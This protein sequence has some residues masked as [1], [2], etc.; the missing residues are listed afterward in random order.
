MDSLEYQWIK[1]FDKRLDLIL[2]KQDMILS[3]LGGTLDS[4]EVRQIAAGIA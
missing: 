2:R 1:Y 4:Q 3:Q